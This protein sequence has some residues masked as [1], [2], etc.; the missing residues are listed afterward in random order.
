MVNIYKRKITGAS[1]Y[2]EANITCDEADLWIGGFSTATFDNFNC[3][4]TCRIHIEGWSTLRINGGHISRATGEI[5]AMSRGVCRAQVD[6]DQVIISGEGNLAK[7]IS[8]QAWKN[9]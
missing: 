7:L 8:L 3:S 4:G 1:S 6:D 5:E 9:Q 2:H